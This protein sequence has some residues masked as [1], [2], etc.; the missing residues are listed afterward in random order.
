MLKKKTVFIQ[1]PNQPIFDIFSD[2]S[3]DFIFEDSVDC[4]EIESYDFELEIKNIKDNYSLEDYKKIKNVIDSIEENF[5]IHKSKLN[6]D[7]GDKLKEL[8]FWKYYEIHND[9]CHFKK[10]HPLLKKITL[11]KTTTVRNNLYTLSFQ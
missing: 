7:Q 6:Q 8:C 2:F 11:K 9:I 5:V 1:E 10:T 3:E 4:L